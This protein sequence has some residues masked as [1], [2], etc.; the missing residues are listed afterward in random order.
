MKEDSIYWS[1][2]PASLQIKMHLLVCE[3][4]NVTLVC[5][6]KLLYTWY[7]NTKT[8][9][10]KKIKNANVKQPLEITG[11]T[12]TAKVAEPSETGGGASEEDS[13]DTKNENKMKKKAAGIVLSL[14]SAR[15]KKPVE[16]EEDDGDDDFEQKDKRK[17]GKPKTNKK[18]AAQK[19]SEKKKKVQKISEEK[20]VEKKDEDEDEDNHEVEV[21]VILWSIGTLMKMGPKDDHITSRMVSSQPFEDTKVKY[22]WADDNEPAFDMSLGWYLV[23]LFEDPKGVKGKKGISKKHKKEMQEKFIARENVLGVDDQRCLHRLKTLAKGY[24]RHDQ[25]THT[26]THTH[27]KQRF[28]YN[29]IRKYDFVCMRRD[30]S[31]LSLNDLVKSTYEFHLVWFSNIVPVDPEK[32]D[33][34]EISENG[35]DVV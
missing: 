22:E 31:Q 3:T 6:A 21:D 12:V 20:E 26:Y 17:G 13:D 35:D 23:T 9:Q 14:K 29:T 28:I 24:A 18:R 19:E 5:A 27:V 1:Q 7:T 15:V 33:R 32:A 2:F 4:C 11:P 8:A 25:N 34:D 30:Q 16:D 10:R